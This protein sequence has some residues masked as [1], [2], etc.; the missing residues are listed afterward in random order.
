MDPGYGSGTGPGGFGAGRNVGDYGTPEKGSFG[1][2]VSPPGDA[3]PGDRRP[4]GTATPAR[5]MRRNREP[6]AD[7]TCSPIVLDL[8][9]DGIEITPLH[10]SSTYFDYNRDGKVGRTAWIGEG[11]GMLVI[12]LARDGGFGP[13]GVIDQAEEFV[14]TQWAKGATSDMEAVRLAFDTNKDGQLSAF[15]LRFASFRIWVDLDG[16]AVVDAGELKTLEELGIASIPLTHD[17][18]VTTYADGSKVLGTS[19]TRDRNGRVI[20]VADTVLALGTNNA[21]I[22][23]VSDGVNVRLGDGTEYNWHVGT[24]DRAA[25]I[26]LGPQG[27]EGAVLRQADGSRLTGL[28]GT[29]GR[30]ITLYRHDAAGRMLGS[31]VWADEQHVRLVFKPSGRLINYDAFGNGAGNAYVGLDEQNLFEGGEGRDTLKGGK[32]NDTLKGDGGNDR[33]FRRSRK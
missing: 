33:L 4:A 23:L 17:G 3:Q 30:L 27:F 19:T 13:D 25:M 5:T 15:D 7:C 8:D 20:T 26:A 18:Q 12:D 22:T 24:G 31:E 21:S 2:E 9:G 32:G 29:D 1:S 14:F 11:D 6:D 16:D 10:Q 28:F